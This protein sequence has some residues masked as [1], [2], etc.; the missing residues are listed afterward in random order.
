MLKFMQP[1]ERYLV[2]DDLTVES[3]HDVLRAGAPDLDSRWTREF[4]TAYYAKHAGGLSAASIVK[5]WRD[6]QA[7]EREAQ[8]RRALLEAPRTPMPDAVR[9]ALRNLGRLDA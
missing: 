7:A 9:A 5:A 4:V 8:E 1:H 3:W 2:V 6:R